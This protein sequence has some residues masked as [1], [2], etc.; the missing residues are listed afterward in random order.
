MDQINE[1]QVFNTS[2]A[3]EILST[4]ERIVGCF[5]KFITENKSEIPAQQIE[6]LISLSVDDEFHFYYGTIRSNSQ[7][8]VD[9]KSRQRYWAIVDSISAFADAIGSYWP[10][11]TQDSRLNRLDHANLH[12]DEFAQY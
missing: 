9:F 5:R 1:S 3:S 6:K 10:Y 12:L 11:M 8:F 7:W 2:K 4:K